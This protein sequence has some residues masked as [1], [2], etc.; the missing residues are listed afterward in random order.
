MQASDPEG[1]P[2]SGPKGA[3]GGGHAQASGGL[4]G[5]FLD[6]LA[7]LSR[8]LRGEIALARAEAAQAGAGLA[9]A[10]TL[11]AVA[12]IVA[13]VGLH[14]LAAAAVAG[15]VRLGLAE[16][17]ATLLAGAVL[18]A[19]ALVLVLRARARLRALPDHLAR[20]LARFPGGGGALATR[21]PA[22]PQPRRTETLGHAG[23]R[24]DAPQDDS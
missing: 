21:P 10:L 18:I 20:V 23:G 9:R 12:A 5:L 14:L 19:L 2:A 15:L 16:P 8:L 6:V 4:A 7:A 13:L 11:V 24:D 22:P 17:L 3:S 1:D